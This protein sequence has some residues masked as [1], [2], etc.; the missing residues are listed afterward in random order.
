MKTFSLYFGYESNT[1]LK[2][3]RV[4]GYAKAANYFRKYVIKE[5]GRTSMIGYVVKCDEPN[6]T[7]YKI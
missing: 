6:E 5:L 4:S 3:V 1:P 7:L 2:K